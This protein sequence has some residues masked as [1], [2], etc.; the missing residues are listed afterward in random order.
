MLMVTEV[1]L[2]RCLVWER[3]QLVPGPQVPAGPWPRWEGQ[4]HGHVFETL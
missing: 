2:I 1:V 3:V 4:V